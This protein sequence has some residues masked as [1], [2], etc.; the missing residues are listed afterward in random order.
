MID[1]NDIH[2]RPNIR[3]S[4]SHSICPSAHTL[5]SLNAIIN[6]TNR[7]I[8]DVVATIVVFFRD[9]CTQGRIRRA[10]VLS[11]LRP[12]PEFFCP[13]E[14]RL[15]YASSP[16]KSGRPA[17]E[18]GDGT[19]RGADEKREEPRL[20]WRVPRSFYLDLDSYRPAKR[21]RPSPVPANDEAEDLDA[22]GPWRLEV[23]VSPAESFGVRNRLARKLRPHQRLGVI[24][25]FECLMGLADY[26]SD[27]LNQPPNETL[28]PSRKMDNGEVSPAAAAGAFGCILADDMGLG[29]TLQSIAVL[30]TFLRFNPS[31]KALLICPASLVGNWAAEIVKWLGPEGTHDLEFVALRES[32]KQKL[33]L[34]IHDFRTRPETRL[35]IC[36]YETF[37][38]N[39]KSFMQ[40]KGLEMFLADEAHRLKNR[41][42]GITKAVT[43]LPVKRRLL[44]T[45]TPMQNKLKEFLVLAQ[46]TNPA[47]FS[48]G[49]IAQRFR[50]ECFDVIAAHF[51]DLKRKE[52]EGRAAAEN[53]GGRGRGRGGGIENENENEGEGEGE[54]SEDEDGGDDGGF[55][56][57]SDAAR[58]NLKL[59]AIIDAFVIRRNN[60]VLAKLLPPKVVAYVFCGLSDAQILYYNAL[61]RGSCSTGDGRGS[62]ILG[63]DEGRPCEIPDKLTAHALALL[64]TLQKLCTHL[65]LVDP[66]K[67]TPA[68]RKAWTACARESQTPQTPQTPHTSEPPLTL[69]VS[70]PLR[71]KAP[72]IA[73]ILE[74]ELLAEEPLSEVTTSAASDRGHSND[75]AHSND[76]ASLSG[77]YYSL[78]SLSK[79]KAVTAAVNGAGTGN[80]GELGASTRGQWGAGNVAQGSHFQ[81]SNEDVFSSGKLGFLFALLSAV[82]KLTS[83]K[84]VIVSN[85]TTSL[86]WIEALAKRNGWPVCKLD[87]SCPLKTRTKMI[88][89]FNTA[90]DRTRHFIFLLSSKA[91]G[92]GVNL[93]GANRLVMLDP[94][95]NPANDRQAL[96][97]VWRDGQKKRCFIYRLFT[98]FSLEE[99]VLE[100]QIRKEALSKVVMPTDRQ[101]PPPGIDPSPSRS[102]PSSPINDTPQVS[103]PQ[104]VKKADIRK[105]QVKKSAV[106]KAAG[107]AL[108]SNLFREISE[109]CFQRKSCLLHE[110][111][112]CASR[113]ACDQFPSPPLATLDPKNSE[114]KDKEKENTIVAYFDEKRLETWDH[115]RALAESDPL[116]QMDAKVVERME[117]ILNGS[118]RG[119]MAPVTFV[120]ACNVRSTAVA[121]SS[122]A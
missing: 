8:L 82:H 108:R 115:A 101:D 97:R 59:S 77:P 54:E 73:T 31:A 113:A 11:F 63:S 87:G 24:F 118:W 57:G 39:Q 90:G 49:P 100:R 120:M 92:A 117:E 75:R 48:H 98:A 30:D 23:R 2:K 6:S 47:L 19:E 21:Q 64:Q 13:T 56:E 105:V 33:K 17:A 93:I 9:R 28:S 116:A 53:R 42:A 94:D 79:S 114:E 102:P 104:D 65:S 74:G 41:E 38:L 29:K 37:R 45:G 51:S 25:V 119:S 1:Q 3:R 52:E 121:F 70:R 66:S 91:G 36:S 80:R 122:P 62:S 14:F 68:V 34:K 4:V 71:D 109:D 89:G 27:F 7:V 22:D 76:F 35:L 95:W 15:P 12:P 85:F 103:P 106:K 72:R 58:A 112:K 46:M 32:V 44:I 5:D 96:A 107:P 16:V 18:S 81:P 69:P 50:V 99:C 83:E 67:L 26:P 88:E 40:V 86:H 111:F 10:K 43:A 55:L 78:R 61:I 110:K 20:S 60:T 84:I